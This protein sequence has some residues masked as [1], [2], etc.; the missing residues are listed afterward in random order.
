[1]LHLAEL[2]VMLLLG[3]IVVV[4]ELAVMGLYGVLLRARG[5]PLH[6][7]VPLMTVRPLSALLWFGGHPLAGQAIHWGWFAFCLWLIL[8]GG[9][10]GPK[11]RRRVKPK[12]EKAPWTF[13]PR[14]LEPV[15]V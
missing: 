15:P 10:G 8:R 5:Y 2:L 7:I 4:V 13:L 11:K 12:A 9:G 14:V 6:V 1:M 3:T